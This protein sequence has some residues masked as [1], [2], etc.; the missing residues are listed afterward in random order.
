M[1]GT[2]TGCRLCPSFRLRESVKKHPCVSTNTHMLVKDVNW[3]DPRFIR[4]G[5]IPTTVQGG[6][7]FYACSLD[8]CVGA[9]G[10][11]GGHVEPTD[12]DALDAALRE[13]SEESLNAFG[14]FTREQLL[15]CEVLVGT[16]T[17]EILVPV[18]PPMYSYVQTFA[19][20]L[21]GNGGHEVLT[22]IWLTGAQLV[23]A[24]DEPQLTVGNTT[25]Y[26][27]YR[28]LRA[29]LDAHRSALVH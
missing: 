3:S 18:P 26:H 13:Y 25:V 5:I 17:V 14:V 29:V 15:E 20:R 28:R 21:N 22:V 10:D 2:H 27:M 12:A 24:V 23:K 9:I 8:N 7:T 4:A 19:T 6:H 16:D 1:Y 11:F